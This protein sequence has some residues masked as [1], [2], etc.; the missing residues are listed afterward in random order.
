MYNAGTVADQ[1]AS[2]HGYIYIRHRAPSTK[3]ACLVTERSEFNDVNPQ[4]STI[5]TIYDQRC[6]WWTAQRPI[7]GPPEPVPTS[8]RLPSYGLE[9][10]FSASNFG[11]KIGRLSKPQNPAKIA[12]KAS[13]TLPQTRPKRLQNDV[14]CCNPRKSKIMQPSHVFAHFLRSQTLENRPKIDAKTPAKSALCWIP[15]WSPKKYDFWC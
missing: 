11:F 9:T 8:G 5:S 3:W 14:L 4:G 10:T 7:L 12:Q 6:R 1:R 15:S 13:K 2:G